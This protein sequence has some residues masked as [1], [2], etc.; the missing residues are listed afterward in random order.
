MELEVP[1]NLV[2]SLSLKS[3]ITF[4]TVLQVVKTFCNLAFAAAVPLTRWSD[5]AT[6]KFESL[7]SAGGVMS[8]YVINIFCRHSNMQRSDSAHYPNEFLW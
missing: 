2:P 1:P 7:G 8:V 3:F 5:I 6:Y 4:C